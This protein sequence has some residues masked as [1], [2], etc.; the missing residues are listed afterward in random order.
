M[1]D[2]TKTVGDVAEIVAA[3]ELIKSGY[4]VSRPLSDNA[5]YDLIYDTGSQLRRAQV[6]GRT[7]VEGKITVELYCN[8]RSYSGKYVLDDFD[9]IIIVDL[10]TYNVAV[11]DVK[12]EQ[13]FES[14]ARYKSFALR[15]QKPLNNQTK[16]VR[17]FSDY[18]IIPQ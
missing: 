18:K 1:K 5:P 7:G 15:T 3:A 12:A 8:A 6:K 17:M 14:T 10:E 11:I 2:N 4:V 9:D 16:G 13:L